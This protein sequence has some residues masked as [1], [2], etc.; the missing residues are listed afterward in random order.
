MIA[1][2]YSKGNQKLGSRQCGEDGLGVVGGTQ[3]TDQSYIRHSKLLPSQPRYKHCKL[4]IKAP[5]SS[6][7]TSLLQQ[8][9]SSTSY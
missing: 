3:D 7:Y 6:K 5:S 9:R 4:T 2:F 8:D 1:V